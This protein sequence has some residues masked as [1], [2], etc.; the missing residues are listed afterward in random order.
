[1]SVSVLKD[2]NTFDK[3][4][5]KIYTPHPVYDHYGTIEPRGS[6]LQKLN[7]DKNYRYILF[8]GF[9]RE[10]KGLDLSKVNKEIVG[11]WKREGTFKKRGRR[12]I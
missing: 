1:M 10:Y 4:K 9:I 11:L 7:L 6:A 5:P 8:F 2:L 12:R 3:K